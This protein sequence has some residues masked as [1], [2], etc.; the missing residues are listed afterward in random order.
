MDVLKFVQLVLTQ[1]SC[2]QFKH[3]YTHSLFRFLWSALKSLHSPLCLNF[4]VYLRLRSRKPDAH[5]A[6]DF[7]YIEV[8]SPETVT[9]KTCNSEDFHILIP[10]KLN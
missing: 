1:E 3:R 7:R 8:K 2:I 5:E 6:S 9:Y 4:K 10:N